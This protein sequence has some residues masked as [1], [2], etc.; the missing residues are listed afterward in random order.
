M[1]D[2]ERFNNIFAII[3]IGIFVVFLMGLFFGQEIRKTFVFIAIG[4]LIAGVVPGLI[5]GGRIRKTEQK[6]I[7]QLIK[8][9]GG[10][11]TE[12]G[13]AKS[14][15]ITLPFK[16]HELVITKFPAGGGRYRH[17]SEK[18]FGEL[19][20]DRPCMPRVTLKNRNQF[21]SREEKERILFN[22]KDFD[23][24][25]LVHAE[26][27][28]VARKIFTKEVREQL[29]TVKGAYKLK[30]T[31]KSFELRALYYVGTTKDFAEL[32]L[33]ILENTWLTDVR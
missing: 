28:R 33:A 24:L 5:L 14:A 18:Y 20:V 27:K 7:R 11:R 30:M 21:K 3:L 12:G 8:E 13:I 16:G 23:R 31:S 22:D 32:A 9:R 25:Y 1:T 29:L 26:D 10:F 2:K 17:S 19:S 6:A 15:F 4:V